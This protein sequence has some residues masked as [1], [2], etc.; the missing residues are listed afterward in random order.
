SMNEFI[1][2]RGIDTINCGVTVGSL[3]SPNEVIHVGDLYHTIKGYKAIIEDNR[4]YGP[5][6][7]SKNKKDGII[8]L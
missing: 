1:S 8:W 5:R 3:H 2:D 4:Y 6:R 7:L